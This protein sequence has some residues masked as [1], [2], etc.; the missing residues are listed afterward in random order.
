[1]LDRQ[2][3]HHIRLR[4]QRETV[5]R[6]GGKADCHSAHRRPARCADKPA[7]VAVAARRRRWWPELN[8]RCCRC[9]RPRKLWRKEHRQRPSPSACLG[10][11][12]SHS[13]RPTTLQQST[14]ILRESDSSRAQQGPATCRPPTWK[15]G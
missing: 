5:G 2:R 14:H 13:H 9:C 4:Q 7:R 10:I 15:P 1:V 11:P 3:L 6:E 12:L 8:A